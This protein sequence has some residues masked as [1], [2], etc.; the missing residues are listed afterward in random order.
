VRLD[1]VVS[2]A[3]LLALSLIFILLRKHDL[4]KKGRITP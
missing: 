4:K 3:A 1:T 2:L